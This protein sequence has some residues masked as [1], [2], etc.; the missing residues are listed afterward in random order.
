MATFARLKSG[1]WRAQVRRK[2]R[3]TSDTFLRRRDAETWALEVERAIDLG[4]ATATKSRKAPTTFGDL[5]STHETDLQDVGKVIR[6]SKAAVLAALRA[7]LGNTPLKDLTRER[8]IEY[9]RRRFKEGAGPVTLSIDFSHIRT[10]LTHAAA[11][12]GVNVFPEEVRLARVALSRL[13][14]IGKSAERDRRP[15]DDEID[16]LIAYFE[17]NP[18]QFIPM[19]RIVRFAIA[20]A[21]RQDELCR[22]EWTG[23][24]LQR[25][26]VTVRD[27]K[28]PRR[29]DG[30]HQKVPLLNLTGFDAW[31]ILLEQK[32][33]T[34]GIGRIF[35]HNGRSVGTAFRR[36]CRE[37]KIED[38][39]FHDLR[40][41]ATSRLF[42]AGLSIERV[43]L[44]TGHKDWRMLRR[45]TNL[46]PEDLVRL[47]KEA[48]PTMEEHLAALVGR[49]VI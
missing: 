14:L 17:S 3:Y 20:T 47:Q 39:R 23:V 32:I 15:T 40:H 9:G 41:E 38:L 25:K 30:N 37:L 34:R 1:H 11:L 21:M 44:V 31:T 42:E 2:G 19:G 26:T 28:D 48:Q 4:Q 45:Y 36:A 33:V 46:K 29:K 6:R 24:D 10:I 18:R 27:R 49:G 22:I 7:A 35:P 13:G 12:H 16:A 5:I 8:L 43:A